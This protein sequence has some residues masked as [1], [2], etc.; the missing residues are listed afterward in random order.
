MDKIN[1]TVVNPDGTEVRQEETTCDMLRRK[2]RAFREKAK[3]K[4][5]EL[6]EWIGNHKKE[7]LAALSI[8]VVLAKKVIKPA[9]VRHQQRERHRIDH[10]Y[11]DPSTGIH[12]ALK[13]KPTNTERAILA[14]RKRAGEPAEVILDDLGLLE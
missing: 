6:I 4:F 13:R 8:L 3:E 14:E 10:T 11:Y 5:G 12:W 2:F 9:G 7:A 1:V